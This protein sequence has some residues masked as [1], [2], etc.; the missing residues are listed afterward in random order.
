V[1]KK[2]LNY[3]RALRGQNPPHHLDLVI[4]FAVIQYPER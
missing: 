2:L 1:T 3:R 4:E